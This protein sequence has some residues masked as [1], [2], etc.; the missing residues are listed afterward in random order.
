MLTSVDENN[1]TTTYTY[2]DPLFRPKTIT[3]PPDT[4][5]GNQSSTTTYNYNDTAA[6]SPSV[7]TTT[8]LNTS[9]SSMTSTSVYDG[10]GRLVQTQL[11]SDPSGT[12]Y[13]STTYDGL[14]RVA[15][16]SNPYRSTTNGSTLYSY[17]SLNRKTLQTQP[18]NSTQQWHYS[19]NITTF[20]DEALNSWVQTSD[21]LGRLQSVGEPN[22]AATGYTYDALN[23]LRTV[24]Q[25]GLSG[26][27]PRTQ[28]NFVYDSLSRLTS[29][30]NPETGTIG[31]GYDANSNLTSKTDARGISS[32]YLYDALNRI[33]QKNYS[34]GTLSAYF[35][36]DGQNQFGGPMA[37]PTSNAKGRVSHVSNG[38]NGGV[39]FSYDSMGRIT[40]QN[41]CVP[42][43]CSYVF[44]ASELYDLAGNLTS[45]TYPDGRTVSQTNDGAGRI[46]AINYASWNGAAQTGSY[47][48]V[49]ST[50]GYDPAGH[51]INATMGNGVSIAAGYDNRERMTALAYGTTTQL[52]WGKALAWTANSNLQTTSDPL[53]G[54]QRQFAYDNL[55]RLTSAQD[56][57]TATAVPDPSPFPVGPGE[58]TGSNIT[59]DGAT[60]QW[61]D[62]DDSNILMNPDA[63]GAEGWGVPN[64]TIVAGV[65]APDGTTTASSF[66]A[67]SGS[68]DTYLTDTV[69][70][71]DLY[72]GE[73]MTGSVWLRSP[74]GTHTINLY[75][76]ENG[77]A[78]FAIPAAKSVTV[79]T[80]WQQF[81]LSGQFQ[82]GHSALLLQIGGG[83]SITSGQTISLWGAKL[84][85]TGTSD[86]SVTNFLPYSQR[87]T[88]STWGVASGTVTDNSA[89]APDGSNTAATVTANSGSSDNYLV[90]T[91]QNPAPYSSSPVTGSVWVRSPSG[92]Q[93][94]LLTLIEI[95]A[96]GFSTLGASTVSL[97]SSWQ[98]FQVSGTTQSTLTSLQ[99]QI[100]GANSFTNGQSI[101]IWGAQ[102]ELASTAGPYVAT[103]GT[104]VSMGTN[105]TNILSYSQQ[106]NAP[107]WSNSYQF[108][109]VVDAVV[110]PDGSQTGYQATAIGGTGWLTNDVLQPAMYDNATLTA[111]VFLRSPSGSD[112]IPLYLVGV[113]ASGS[114]L[115]QQSTAQLTSTWQRFT[116]TGQAPNGMT[117][118]YIQ[119]GDTFTAGQVID[120]WG[121][122]MEIAS[123]A[124]PY[125]M[126]TAMPVIA[127]TELANILPNSQQL[128]G[129]GWGVAN[130][131]ITVNAATAPDGTMTGATVTATANSPDTYI[132]DSVPNPSLYD[133]QT[134][135]GSVYLR[136]SGTLNTYLFLI[137]VGDVGFSVSAEVPI[138]LTTSWQRFSITGTNQNGLSELQLQIGGGST[139]TSGQSFQVWGAQMVIGSDPAPYVPTSTTTTNEVTGQTATFVPNGLDQSYAYDSFGNLQQ[140]GGFNSRYTT[141][142]QMLG[143]AYDA[144]GNLL[145]NGITSMTW[146]A[147]SRISSAGGAT[148]IYDGE[149]NRIEKQGV[150]VTDTVY[151]GNRPLARLSAGSWT[152]LIYG[153]N[154]LMA[155]VPGT[156]TAQP[157]YRLL[158]HLG[159]QVGTVSTSALITDPLDYTPFG[160]NF[161]GATN[162][163]YQ[164]TG[165]ERDAESGLDYF[166]YRMYASNMGRW[167]SPDPSGLTHADLGNPQSLNLYSYVGN[168]P[169]TR[170]DL[171]GLCWKGF[172]WACDVGQRFKNSLS[173]GFITDKQVDARVRQGQDNLRNHGVS[174][175]GLSRVAIAGA[176]GRFG[177]TWQTYIKRHPDL[178]PYAGRTSG[179]GTP[180]Q[181]LLRRDASHQMN[182]KGFGEA[183]LDKSSSNPDAIRGRE[184]Q[185]IDANGGAQ[186]QG[187]TSS[188]I[189]NGIAESNPNRTN[190][191]NAA[192]AEFGAEEGTS[193]A[194]GVV[195]TVEIL[196][197][198]PD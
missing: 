132:V 177:K 193:T 131:S 118:L 141:Q 7:T 98:R 11:T 4:N 23:N 54:I 138:T 99:L 66:T 170:A 115:F 72:D 198:I 189:S 37:T 136:A 159:N 129:P 68:T 151:F 134:M 95:G 64:A 146:D 17:D 135:T 29:S 91:V 73:T 144:A 65:A 25:N 48:T 109:G 120:V 42:T 59:S 133:S 71:T 157:S 76:I 56:I 92:S 58:P 119:V 41:Y 36:Y 26:E 142:N 153:P 9:G 116:I 114:V 123:T 20:T 150:G 168:S 74:S 125:V 172:Q 49:P 180:E 79:T 101:Q 67:N 10:L 35:G 179:T 178:E 33:I 149:G 167:M 45:Q 121:S 43:N 117:R 55:N 77:T 186:S 173:Y 34:D 52:L 187:G 89:V 152:D 47:L 87:F 100:G 39:N 80:A 175:E 182:E 188:N 107:S 156:E 106:P 126:T 147:E 190:Y 191:M 194:E 5:N 27:A 50:N 82:Y 53:T 124:G 104:A 94:I 143:Y 130:G 137:N 110:A 184:Q 160:Q 181:N 166:K 60:P 112:S 40:K 140:N 57:F 148:Y 185:L 111:S 103:G 69:M 93:S 46:S 3:G 62:P 21:G 75:L 88:A 14:G 108:T 165:K 22:L 122:Q 164:F 169:L 163:P 84:E 44:A 90:D 105:L 19:G 162:D 81:Q 15:S 31:Y 32:S 174:P 24:T 96:S 127:G 154:G 8:L 195:T 38:V 83:G 2:D 158:D 176:A 61:T 70:N 197:E 192:E 139:V 183:E 13:T 28:R 51:L 6:P 97:T 85:D 63:P 1:Q 145:S 102:V 86:P 128:S 16:T 30:S 161:S 196:N 18:D 171:D 155:E 113:N 12:D 78:G